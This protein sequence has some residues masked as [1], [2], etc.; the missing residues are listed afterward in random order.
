[1]NNRTRKL[2]FDILDSGRSIQTWCQD[3]SY[4]DYEANR[5]L[6]RAVERE[7]EI[8]GEALNHLAQS[9]PET[10]SRINHLPRIVSFRNRI[11]HGYD[12]VD[13]ATVWGVIERY[14]SSLLTEVD[15]LL[16]QAGG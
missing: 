9:D 11:I 13:N 4:E 15:S 14:L 3:A 1:M 7:F 12:T 16:A 5:Q 6:R 8:I 10:A 2:L